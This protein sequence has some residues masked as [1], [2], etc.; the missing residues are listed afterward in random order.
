MTV[1]L[2]LKLAV[3]GQKRVS[4]AAPI[5]V[6]ITRLSCFD[7][8]KKPSKRKKTGKQRK[9]E[10]GWGTEADPFPGTVT[11]TLVERDTW[12]AGDDVVSDQIDQR[13]AIKDDEIITIPGTLRLHP[14]ASKGAMFEPDETA[15][16]KAVASVASASGDR[17]WFNFDGRTGSAFEV[18]IPKDKEEGDESH[19]F[20]FSAMITGLPAGVEKFSEESKVVAVR[21]PRN[22]HQML[23][24][25]PLAQAVTNANSKL[26]GVMVD[27]FRPNATKEEKK[28]F[29]DREWSKFMLRRTS[30]VA[31]MSEIVNSGCSLL[32]IAMVL[33]YLRVPS[34]DG[35]ISVYD[36]VIGPMLEEGSFEAKFAP[37]ALRYDNTASISAAASVYKGKK[38]KSQRQAL[39]KHL[40][41]NGLS[42]DPDFFGI[43]FAAETFLDT[44]EE[45]KVFVEPATVK[46]HYYPVMLLWYMRQKQGSND[47]YDV[48]V[49]TARKQV[50]KE[51]DG[52]TTLTLETVELKDGA[53][54]RIIRPAHQELDTTT[55]TYYA[56]KKGHAFP[57]SK[58]MKNDFGVTSK[59]TEVE[60]LGA[61]WPQFV[62]DTI[63]EGLPLIAIMSPGVYTTAV[64]LA[65]TS[66][67]WVVITGYRT[68][69]DDT[70]RFI[71]NDPARGGA[72]Q[73]DVLYEEQFDD[74]LAPALE[75]IAAE[76]NAKNEAT[77]KKRKNE[78]LRTDFTGQEIHD[79]AVKPRERKNN[80]FL[81]RR[82]LLTP[83][84]FHVIKPKGWDPAHAKVLEYDGRSKWKDV[85][86]TA[87][88]VKPVDP[89]SQ[90]E[91]DND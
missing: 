24:V 71:I 69:E 39:Q 81:D 80:L 20:E 62:K 19:F 38:K 43:D 60:G 30:K 51:V 5:V 36:K 52:V 37:R 6:S 89:P 1:Q 49:L 27:A 57:L 13:E 25:E 55:N 70:V 22:R 77:N 54:A 42:T 45:G 11:M 78:K 2:K 32:V 33:R 74:F 28:L 12:T 84:V 14:T 73:Y 66:G 34:D 67:H 35:T 87:M 15:L 16:S 61:D 44:S 83:R 7:P 68:D 59:A 79:E 85:S 23:A 8:P 88:V 76:R 56:N 75:Q 18:P 82:K 4:E 26:L 48:E 64:G 90:E 9:R 53:P 21:R 46:A 50:L 63:D 47:K 91:E 17:A 65:G 58:D 3:K 72:M 29:K 31:F 86:P 10:V 40:E 41:D